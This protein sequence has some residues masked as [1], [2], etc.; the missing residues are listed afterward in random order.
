M[1]GCVHRG[2]LRAR[3]QPSREKR[4]RI[5]DASEQQ[6]REKD[7]PADLVNTHGRCVCASDEKHEACAGKVDGHE[8]ECDRE[9][10]LEDAG[11]TQSDEPRDDEHDPPDKPRYHARDG[12]G[13]PTGDECRSVFEIRSA[14]TACLVKNA[15]RRDKGKYQE[16]AGKCVENDAFVRVSAFFHETMFREIRIQ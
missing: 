4:S 12:R 8:D 15:H 5:E 9:H 10:C 2:E 3:A 14:H 11:D 16:N 6:E 7:Q 13:D 1:H